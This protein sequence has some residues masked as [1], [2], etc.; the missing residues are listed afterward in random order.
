MTMPAPYGIRPS[1]R[2]TQD[3]TLDPLQAGRPLGCGPE[4]RGQSSDPQWLVAKQYLAEVRLQA[5]AMSLR[6]GLLHH[7]SG[8]KILNLP[9]SGLQFGDLRPGKNAC[10]QP[11]GIQRL[12]HRLYINPDRCDLT[13]GN[14]HHALRMGQVE[15]WKSG[16][17]KRGLAGTA[18]H[19]VAGVGGIRRRS[20]HPAQQPMCRGKGRAIPVKAQTGHPLPLDR[21][22]QSCVILNFF[23]PDARPEDIDTDG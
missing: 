6:K 22:Q 11:L 18:P 23:G 17:R 16:R 9:S 3:M 20:Q 1:H 2:R 14:G 21:A 12:G 13:Q 10:G 19:E 7:P 8:K 15:L 4:F 5:A